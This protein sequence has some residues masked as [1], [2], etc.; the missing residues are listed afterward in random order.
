MGKWA[1]LMSF[2]STKDVVP[3]KTLQSIHVFLISC[4]AS[5]GLGLLSHTVEISIFMLASMDKVVLRD[6]Y[7]WERDSLQNHLFSLSVG[8]GSLLH[9]LVGEAFSLL[10]TWV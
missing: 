2:L 7:L 5:G 8:S 10:P 9:I 6:L 1:I 4:Y 3:C